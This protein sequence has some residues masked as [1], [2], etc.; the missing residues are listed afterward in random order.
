MPKVKDL[1]LGYNAKTNTWRGYMYEP[2]WGSYIGIQTLVNIHDIALCAG[3]NCIMHNPSDH[4]M[5]GW[6]LS[7]RGDKRVF[8]RTC[9]DGL[10]HPDPDD[11][12][13]LVSIGQGYLTNHGCDG[14]CKL[15]D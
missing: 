5:I 10:G 15:L 8:E 2:V 6:K 14:C 3:R 1:K 12:K 7:W 9:P 4:H 11:A 13:Y